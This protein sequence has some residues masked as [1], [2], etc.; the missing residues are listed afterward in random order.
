MRERLVTTK[1]RLTDVYILIIKP[2]RCTNF[3]IFFLIKLFMFR[4]AAQQQ[5]QT[6]SVQIL[7]ARCQQTCMT[8]II[9]V[10]TVK[11]S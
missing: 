8:Y 9:A 7:L 6:S 2:N 1:P 10:C 5:N 11:N 4:T 3:S